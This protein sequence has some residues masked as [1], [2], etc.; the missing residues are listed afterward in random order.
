MI[1]SFGDKA[2]DTSHRVPNVKPESEAID[3]EIYRMLGI[4]LD[5]LAAHY[6]EQ[7]DLAIM[8][9]ETES[10]IMFSEVGV[11][12]CGSGVKF[13]SKVHMEEDIEDVDD[14]VSTLTSASEG[15]TFS[16]V[17]NPAPTATVVDSCSASMDLF[18]KD[19]IIKKW[20][21]GRPKGSRHKTLAETSYKKT[22]NK[23][24]SPKVGNVVEEDAANYVQEEDGN[25]AEEE[26]GANGV[27]DE[28]AGNGVEQDAGVE[29][30]E[31]VLQDLVFRRMQDPVF[32]RRQEKAG[33][34][35]NVVEQDADSEMDNYEAW[36]EVVSGAWPAIGCPVAATFFGLPGCLFYLSIGGL[37]HLFAPT[38]KRF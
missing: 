2:I 33:M 12:D 3:I 38:P 24:P 18:I 26:D 15:K 19:P 10:V 4:P 9:I 14:A 17:R 8:E 5:V 29:E 36:D 25:G 13:R 11:G 35:G 32:R 7:E 31:M 30:E 20:K 34:A 22:K 21:R 23:K 16:S 1:S 6:G 27:E 28:D 37:G